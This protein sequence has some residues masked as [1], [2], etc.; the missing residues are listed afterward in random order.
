M[1]VP[2]RLSLR[3][4]ATAVVACAALAASAATADAG[5]LVAS[6]SSCD[7]QALSKPFE[8]WLDPADYTALSGGDF[9]GDGAGWSTTGNAAI[10]NGNETFKVGGAGDAKSLAIG[11][12][13]SATS[14][15]IC[16]GIEHPTIRFFAK[17]RSAGLLSSLSTLRVEALTETATNAILTTPV[18][19]VASP[20]SW[21]PTLP[22]PIVTNLL[23]LLPG[24]HTA[25]AFR[26]TAVGGDWSVDDVWVDPY[27]RR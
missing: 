7:D 6:A 21:Q 13:G 5:I 26:F 27:N 2:R 9:E 3:T 22:L 1:P 20:N 19:V 17:R 14:P 12:G 16:V 15:S 23:P 25:V 18:G 11:A 10:A 4:G 8:P 24:E